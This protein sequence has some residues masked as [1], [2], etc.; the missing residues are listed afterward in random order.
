MA[1]EP[2]PTATTDNVRDS[3]AVSDEPISSTELNFLRHIV[4][5]LLSAWL[6]YQGIW[7]T[8]GNHEMGDATEYILMTN[9]LLR[10]GSPD[11]RVGD[12]ENS[13]V[14]ERLNN[15]QGARDRL[16]GFVPAS[17]G[18][19]YCWHF[20][21]YP[22]INIPMRNVVEFYG[23]PR[24]QTF[25]LT[26]ALLTVCVIGQMLYMTKRY[27]LGLQ[28]I[29]AGLYVWS[30]Q[31]WY[32][33]WPHPE[34]MS[35]AFVFSSLIFWFHDYRYAAI[36]LSALASMQN[37]PLFLLVLFYLLPT[38]FRKTSNTLL[39]VFL[40][41]ISSF[42]VIVPPLFYK[43][44]YGVG[45]LI[46]D[47]GYLNNNL[48]SF[49]RFW[50]FFFDLNQGMIISMPTALPLFIF[51]Y[52]ASL[53]NVTRRSYN[54]WLVPVLI[55]MTF[56]FMPMTNWNHGQA[57]I[58]RYATWCSMIPLAYLIDLVSRGWNRYRLIAMAT[59]VLGPQILVVQYFYGGINWKGDQ[60][61]HKA[62][63]AFVLEHFPR[64]YNPDPYIFLIR[65]TGHDWEFPDVLPYFGKDGKVRKLAVKHGS[66]QQLRDYG[67]SADEANRVVEESH[68]ING[69]T[70]VHPGDFQDDKD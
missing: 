36:F 47:Y 42:W 37:P 7:G 60:R 23:L 51:L 53:S 65:T 43:Y 10:H 44:H 59:L 22:I 26:H 68:F 19:W 56:F 13:E 11:L 15:P 69:W 67:W 55:G 70:Y 57:V 62:L 28:I 27:P 54:L 4:F 9:A 66:E 30:S 1:T 2:Q 58:N 3:F 21:V 63:A 16:L 25:P 5:G 35:C 48:I 41:G 40:C 12:A 14:D 32:F 29:G 18:R 38:V 39:N 64:L 17:N 45:S 50:G 31:L 24:M 6:L 49:T 8:T 52:L 61:E 20:F 34:V 46:I 33:T